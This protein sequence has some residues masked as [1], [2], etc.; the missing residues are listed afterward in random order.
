MKKTLFISLICFYLSGIVARSQGCIPVRN[1]V[2]FGQFAHPEFESLDQDQ[3]K[4]LLNVN[5]RYYEAYQIYDGDQPVKGVPQDRRVNHT[6]VVNFSLSRMLENGWSY[7]LDVPI[8]AASR[9]S[10]QE[11]SPDSVRHTTQT[12]GLGDIRIAVYKWSWDV[13]MTHRGNVQL[14]LGVKLP[15]GDYRY[16]DYFY[17]PTGKVLAPVNSTIQ[18]GD[19]GTGITLEANA[20]YRVSR[21][22]SL[23]GNLFYLINPKDQNGVSNYEWWYSQGTW[24]AEHSQ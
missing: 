14:G 23:Y 17:K 22:I 15:T 19:G 11:H 12:F 18:L 2:G 6:F 16:Q 1:L 4:W 24:P 13:S 10:W 9:T 5:S 3:V 7:A 20:F 8:V 21:T